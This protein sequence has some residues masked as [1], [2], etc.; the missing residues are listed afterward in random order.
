MSRSRLLCGTPR[1]ITSTTASQPTCWRLTAW[2]LPSVSAESTRRPTDLVR[3]HDGS[4]SGSRRGFLP[5][6]H[7][8]KIYKNLRRNFLHMRTLSTNWEHNKGQGS[9]RGECPIPSQHASSSL[10]P[11]F[12]RSC[13][14]FSS[15]RSGHR[16]YHSATSHYLPQ[17]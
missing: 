15:D 5:D 9:G 10:S 11:P 2:H 1:R 12:V 14:E 3:N 6:S 17:K 4:P 7:F 13:G 16:L 8:T